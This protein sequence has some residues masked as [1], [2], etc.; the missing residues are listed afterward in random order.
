MTASGEHGGPKGA[1]AG[2]E[3]TRY[4]TST[5]QAIMPLHV[6]TFGTFPVLAESINFQQP[7]AVGAGRDPAYF[8]S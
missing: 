3:P 4:G 8:G 1:Y 7:C 5:I 6:L 2:A